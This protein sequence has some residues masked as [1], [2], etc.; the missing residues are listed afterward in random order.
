IRRQVA[1]ALEKRQHPLAV[2]FA[3]LLIERAAIDGLGKQLRD[4]PARVV[5]G[6]TH[7]DRVAAVRG[8]VEEPRSTAGIN[9]DLERHAELL[10]I[11]E[12]RLVMA[13]K[14]SRAG[15]PVELRVKVADLAGAVGQV[16]ACTLSYSPGAP[17]HAVA[18]LQHRAVVSGPAEL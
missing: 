1:V 14:A 9:L 5:D 13:R 16:D 7:L 10:T 2:A 4:R 8:R 15:I 12:N 11:A 6:L 18:R 3:Q 17:A